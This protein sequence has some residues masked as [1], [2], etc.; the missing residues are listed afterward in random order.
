MKIK[1]LF[2][3]AWIG[4][5]LSMSVMAQEPL[6][7]DLQ[8]QKHVTTETTSDTGFYIS[9]VIDARP[10]YTRIG[11]IQCENTPLLTQLCFQ[12]GIEKQLHT[13]FGQSQ[14]VRI[15]YQPIIVKI[16]RMWVSEYTTA[17]EMG[18][19]AVALDFMAAQKDGFS[20]LFRAF[21]LVQ[22]EGIDVRKLHEP[23]LVKALTDCLEQ[24]RNSNWQATLTQT[25]VLTTQ[26]LSESETQFAHTDLPVL[27]GSLPS[28]GIYQTFLDFRNN[29]ADSKLPLIVK[30]RSHL[31]TK[32]NKIT[33]EQELPDRGQEAVEEAWGFSDG[34]QAYIH[35]QKEY[36]PLRPVEGGFVFEA[37]PMPEAYTGGS[38]TTSSTRS[39]ILDGG[40]TG[41]LTGVMNVNYRQPY[42][43]DAYTG[44]ITAW[45]PEIP[46]LH[47]TPVSTQAIQSDVANLTIYY[48]A[49][50]KTTAK[51]VHIVFS[52]GTRSIVKELKPGTFVQIP[53]KDCSS[54]LII[55]IQESHSPCYTF[56]PDKSEQYLEYLPVNSQ[57]DI[58]IRPVRSR[59]ALFYL[60]QLESV[61]EQATGNKV[62][63]KGE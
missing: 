46:K 55:C 32:R 43:L 59:E 26:Q 37:Y 25:P 51:P 30:N 47:E 35:F 21:S 15:G 45:H 27:K 57:E 6:W 17:Y 40:I 62:E 63:T 13:F 53:W 54:E 50:K 10:G 8:P 31:G 2:C 61:L 36:F 42:F 41:T 9:R 4:I 18:T 52:S 38:M 39:G 14:P 19:A 1:Q 60:A 49:S 16:N 48:K 28:Q 29:H 3:T 22:S 58:T 5:A 23:N 56:V 44:Q 24:F 7:I 34:K 20:L 11:F 12:G 33:I